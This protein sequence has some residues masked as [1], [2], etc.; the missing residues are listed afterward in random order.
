MEEGPY[1]AR[2]EAARS[3][4]RIA[5]PRAIPALFDTLDEDSALIEYWANEAFEKMG[6]GMAFFKP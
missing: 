4:A 5:D 2:L 1:L 3:L 6:V